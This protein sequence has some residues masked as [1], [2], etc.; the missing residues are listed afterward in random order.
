MRKLLLAAAVMIAVAS[1][2][3]EEEKGYKIFPNKDACRAKCEEFLEVA[4]KEGM[5]EAF[6][7]IE[8]FWPFPGTE[9]SMVQVQSVKQMGLVKP[10][11]GKC[12]GY[13]F[14]KEQSV[15]DTVLRFVYIQKFERHI[16]RW[17][18]VFYKPEKEWLLNT[19]FW[20]DQIEELFS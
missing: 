12:V 2:A 4:V 14:V 19:F 16:L 6:R 5:D 1:Y 10:R 17:R 7:V 20:D 13:E 11:F 3:A 8:P 9:F 15:N 18:F